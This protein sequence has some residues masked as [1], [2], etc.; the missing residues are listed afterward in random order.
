M[1][2]N[3]RVQRSS[4]AKRRATHLDAARWW[5]PHS[6]PIHMV[7]KRRKHM[8]VPSVTNTCRRRCFT[9][10]EEWHRSG[11]C[12]VRAADGITVCAAFNLISSDHFR[13]FFGAPELRQ[14]HT[15]RLHADLNTVVLQWFPQ[16]TPRNKILF[17]A[18][19]SVTW[20]CNVLPVMAAFG[21]SAVSRAELR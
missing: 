16:G 4:V 12:E 11:L 15:H 6:K 19:T 5:W 7:G 2:F 8:S 9:P 1:I 14:S 20:H 17:I 21:S 18:F 10:A 3:T 13:E